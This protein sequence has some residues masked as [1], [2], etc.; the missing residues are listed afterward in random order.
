M[1]FDYIIQNPPY[2]RSLH[3]EF[4]RKGL[5]LLSK[6]GKMTI[7]EPATWLINVRKNGKAKLYD[8]IKSRLGKHVKKV[9]IEN[10]NRE[11]DTALYMPF[12]IT[13]IDLENEYDNID[14]YCCGEYRKVNNLYDC[15]LIGNYDTIWS[16]LNKCKNYGNVMKDHIYKK[17]KIPFNNNIHF[18]A[19]SELIGRSGVGDPRFS[20][21]WFINGHYTNC[22]YPF[23]NFNEEITQ[24]AI[25]ILKSGYTYNN[26]KYSDKLANQLYGTKEELENWKHFVF[27][28]K[29]PLF[30]SLVLT[31]AQNNNVKEFTPWLTDKQYTNEEIYS[32]LNITKD[33]QE[34]IDKTIK[35]YERYSPWFKRYMC[36]KAGTIKDNIC[37]VDKKKVNEDIWFCKYAE[38]FGGAGGSF[39]GTANPVLNGANFDSPAMYITHINGEY[40]TSYLSSCY[41]YY[42]NNIQQS[43]LF[44]YDVGKKL[45]DKVAN[46]LYGTKQELEN[47]K[48]FVFNNKLPLFISLVLTID[49][50]NNSKEFTPWLADQHYTDEEIYNLLGITEEEQ[51]FIDKTIKKYERHS[52]WFKRYMCGKDSVSS[53]EIQKFIDNL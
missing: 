40:I 53:E 50:H 15:N 1:K 8:E 9:V 33:E 30:I 38:I 25:Y 7:I 2:K 17:G 20:D 35:K 11:F 16:I 48:H 31:I 6:N 44:A 39:C 43:P 36:G 26:P 45:T 29:L 10:F 51:K 3:L 13:Y 28:N 23:F 5:D 52:P 37:N 21:N 32:L 19:Y 22:Y 4:F 49:Q 34:F 41:H 12:S 14:L 47:W 24:K 46:N 18:A 42:N 27:N